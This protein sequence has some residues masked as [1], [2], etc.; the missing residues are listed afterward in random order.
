[1][2]QNKIER[3]WLGGGFFVVVVVVVKIFWVPQTCLNAGFAGPLRLRPADAGHS[4]PAASGRLRRENNNLKMWRPK[5]WA[6]G[7]VTTFF[8]VT[9]STDPKRFIFNMRS[10]WDQFEIVRYFSDVFG[11]LN[12]Q[13]LHFE[14]KCCQN[15]LT[16]SLRKMQLV[17][18]QKMDFSDFDA[19]AF[20]ASE[21]RVL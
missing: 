12:C 17:D 14:R 4:R 18:P 15:L 20:W 2:I 1:M 11:S 21:T 16:K 13:N 19:F 6:I 10:F 9:I 3:P 8:F 5:R 7:G